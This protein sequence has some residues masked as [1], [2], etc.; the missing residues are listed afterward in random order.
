VVPRNLS[1][2]WPWLLLAACALVPRIVGAVVRPPW[3]DEYF[4]AWVAGLSWRH[5]LAALRL[6]SGPPLPY[7]LAKLLAS[8]GLPPLA[9]A[10]VVSVAAGSAAVLLAAAA[11]R[12]AFGAAAG[13]WTGA[14]VAVHPLAVFWS[15]GGRAYAL[16]FAAVAWAWERLERL[17]NDGRGTVGLALAVS[18]GCWSHAFGLV[19][20]GTLVLAAL[21]LGSPSR[22]RALLAVGIGLA[23]NLPWLP[24]ALTQPPA[25]TAWMRDAWTA[26]PAIEK[27]AAPA[28]LLPPAASFGSQLDLPSAPVLLQA[29]AA[30]LAV[31]LLVAAVRAVRPWLLVL[32]PAGGLA[33]LAAAGAAAFYGGR[34][35][36]LYLAPFLALL[37]TAAGRGRAGRAAGA[38]LVACG[39]LVCGVALRDW[40]HRPPSGE[41]RLAAAIRRALP[42]GGTIIVG[43]YWRLGLKYHL[44]AAAVSF[45]LV[46]FPA[47]AAAHPGWYDP[48][49]DR[50]SPAELEGLVAELRR[51]L[52]R[53]AVVENPSLPTAGDLTLLARALGL[54][55]T[56][57]VPGGVL[58]E[59]R[60]L[61]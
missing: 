43:G 22:H 6:D 27:L 14:L 16:L 53:T 37:A 34:A 12:R 18:L 49:V 39:A 33:A 44:G 21:T 23:S 28:R 3:H 9:A 56:L 60:P 30:I 15:C 32:V 1:A 11:A 19:L 31:G 25:A 10:R 50:P 13:W 20:A 36:V 4:T 38:L 5:M 40:Q 46:N 47:E 2:I 57:A 41:A 17:T 59:P 61:S 42:E 8:T 58:Y 24:I 45:R 55:R 29:A 51:E 52:P 54:R 26:L 48:R 35:E 7:A